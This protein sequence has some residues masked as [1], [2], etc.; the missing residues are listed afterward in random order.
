V[1]CWS[2]TVPQLSTVAIQNNPIGMALY[3]LGDWFHLPAHAYL[4]G[5]NHVADHNSGGH[6]SYLLGLR[7]DTGWWYYFP[8]VFAVKSTIAALAATVLLLSA[9]L[10]Q[11]WKR[12]W[13][14]PMTLGLALPPAIY[15]VCSMTSGI[16][17]GMRHI[18]PVYPFL[19]VGA[20]A[21]LTTRPN[22]RIS[23][24]ALA[25]VVLLQM[26]ESARIAPDYLA[27]FNELAGG[28][29][30]GPEYLVDSN[31][32]WGQDVK[33]LAH[34]LDAHGGRRVRVFYFGNA[35]MRYYG[36][37]EMGYPQPLD[38]QG[39]DEV[40]EY[41]VANVTPLQGV[42]VPLNILAPLRLREPIAKIGWS[43]YV[44]DLHK[45]KPGTAHR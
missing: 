15:F 12:E 44:Y 21:W 13:I 4:L 16:N 26:A 38:Q 2:T 18:L 25:A 5:L 30:R 9:C 42:Y 29:G 34:W 17:I 37:D 31:I 7:S 6:A 36:I 23:A 32:D 45:P 43:M 39:W 19:Y 11:L 10:W 3:W 28:P 8:V 40:D 14:S 41:C 27:F 24:Y 35:Q 22:R 20:A 1:R 33:K